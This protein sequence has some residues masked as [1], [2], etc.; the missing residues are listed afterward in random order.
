MKRSKEEMYGYAI[1]KTSRSLLRFL[2]GHLKGYGITPEQWTVLKR[3]SEYDGIS[4]KELAAVADKD[5]ATLAKM[6]DIMERE[7]IIARST[8]PEDRRSFLI[9]ITGKGM[10]LKNTV[11]EFL[12]QIFDDVIEGIPD[13]EIAVFNRVLLQIEKNAIAHAKN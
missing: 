7:E 5:P 1:T 11:H 9:C 4:Q 8:N 2:T 13:E 6:L 10:D 3:V 12:E